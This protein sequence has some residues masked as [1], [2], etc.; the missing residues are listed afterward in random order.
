MLDKIGDENPFAI[1]LT[2]DL[3]CRSPTFWDDE[4]IESSEGKEL[5]NLTLS[6]GLKQVI[7]KP[8]HFPRDGIATCIGH[9]FTN[10]ENI[11]CDNG[12]VPSPDPCCIPPLYERKIW[13]YHNA[14]IGQI[15]SKLSNMNWNMLFTGKSPEQ[16]VDILQKLFL[17]LMNKFI[18]N[19]IK[20]INYK[21]APWVTPAV[22]TALRRNKRV[23][24][25][26]IEGSNP[27]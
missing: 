11:L 7:N 22:K 6:N 24:K 5:N 26:W 20:N 23:F 14:D 27:G 3:N 13:E 2:G 17:E 18:P 15:R 12:V 10:Q 19:K 1:I 21:D 16:L 4:I 9:I 8:T 25:I